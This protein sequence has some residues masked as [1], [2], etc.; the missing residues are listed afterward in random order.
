[1]ASQAVLTALKN[2]TDA[3]AKL[4]EGRL[5]RKNLGD[6]S[7]EVPLKPILAQLKRKL[8]FANRYAPLV[9]DSHVTHVQQHFQ[10]AV[11]GLGQQAQLASAGEYI[12]NKQGLLNNLNAWLDAINVNWA[13]FVA[14]AVE[15]RGFLEDEGIRKEY[16]QTLT[17]MQTETK[18]ALEDVRKESTAAIQEA[19][20][21]A[22]EIEARARKTAARI[23]VEAAQAQFGE[24]QKQLRLF[25]IV[26]A[27]L[28][29]VSLA[30]LAALLSSFL[31]DKLPDGWS[32]QVA[33]Y[34]A[35]H[36]TTLAVVGS[37]ASYCM[38]VLK[39]QLHQYLLNMH[40]QRVTNS[41][42][43]FVESAVTPEQRDMILGH[44]VES[45]VNFG[46]SGLLD[47][48]TSGEGVT[49]KLTVD[50]ITRAIVS[51]AKDSK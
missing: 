4:D 11:A 26:W 37:V 1:M 15:S 34:A 29:I 48:D 32:W 47:G 44:L 41:I 2:T 10:A 50:N 3:F 14:A 49:P 33:Y 23:S 40:R 13:A 7:L 51:P 46:H 19:K 35:I 45:V 28:S 16:E 6:E 18:S 39:A 21:L 9:H 43:A 31:N 25:V 38:R 42:A 27:G 5:L 36:L 24:A 17:Q 20:K 22:E 12:A 30:I 8:D